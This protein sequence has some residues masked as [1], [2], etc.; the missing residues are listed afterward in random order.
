MWTAS[1]DQTAY[2]V[3]GTLFSD[4]EV[5]HGLPV[6]V[7]DS[8]VLSPCSLRVEGASGDQLSTTCLPSNE[9]SLI[10]TNISP[11]RLMGMWEGRYSGPTNPPPNPA[12]IPSGGYEVGVAVSEMVASLYRA[13]S[14][15]QKYAWFA[16]STL[17]WAN[18]SP[19]YNV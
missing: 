10:F 2:R 15:H 12:Y 5:L 11:Y 6:S 19:S 17:Q 9:S 18:F 1:R 13:A 16:K 8:P 7:T 4:M 3:S 14:K